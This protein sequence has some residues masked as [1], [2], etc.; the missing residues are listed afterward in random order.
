MKSVQE[1]LAACAARGSSDESADPPSIVNLEFK[2]EDLIAALT[3]SKS[4]SKH[5]VK[6]LAGCE[7]SSANSSLIIQKEHLVESLTSEPT[8]VQ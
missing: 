2:R 3:A 7:A 8:H 4:T 5:K 1:I 6:L